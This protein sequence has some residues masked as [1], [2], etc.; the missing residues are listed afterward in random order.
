MNFGNPVRMRVLATAAPSRPLAILLLLAAACRTGAEPLVPW[1]AGGTV[2]GETDDATGF[3]VVDESDANPLAGVCSI[4]APSMPCS[5]PGATCGIPVGAMCCGDTCTCGA[6]HVWTCTLSCGC[7][8]TTLLDGGDS[9][10]R[11]AVADTGLEVSFITD[12]TDAPTDVVTQ[13]PLDASCE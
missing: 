3:V 10:R 8:G 11:D 9:V 1:D 5:P 4:D 6:D 13:C 12:A 2:D 7:R